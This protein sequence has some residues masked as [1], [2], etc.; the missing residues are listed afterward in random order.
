[1]PI[2][3]ARL[4]DLALRAE[5]YLETKYH[6]PVHIRAI[7]KP[8]HGDLDGAEIDIDGDTEPAERL[9]LILHL[10]G[11][12]VQW[13]TSERAREIGR[14][15]PVPVS[16][17]LLPELLAYEREAAGYAV[18]LLHEL[19]ASDLDGWFSDIAEADLAYL[20]HYYR[21][22]EKRPVTEF[23]R[24]NCPVVQPKPIPP[25]QPQQWI[26]RADGVVI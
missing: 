22:G 6:L 9:F 26:F 17:E 23:F 16:E 8:F 25:F 2:D 11:H 5:E 15:L 4:N 7:P 13:D 3:S 21:T 10:F 24:A 14:P 19:G 1:M 12:T 18:E 20:T